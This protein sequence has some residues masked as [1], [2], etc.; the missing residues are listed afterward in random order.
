LEG[1]LRRAV[2]RLEAARAERD[3]ELFGFRYDTRGAA[4]DPAASASANEEAALRQC[5]R[6]GATYWGQTFRSDRKRSSASMAAR[7][8]VLMDTYARIA[9]VCPGILDHIRAR[10]PGFAEALE[11][12]ES[13]ALGRLPS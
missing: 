8:R 5:L 10:S 1:D 11:W 3:A 6:L 13:C 2:A 7:I 4:L 12:I 9:A